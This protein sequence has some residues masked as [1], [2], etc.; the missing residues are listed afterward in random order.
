MIVYSLLDSVK[1]ANQWYVVLG[2]SLNIQSYEDSRDSAP[3]L[4]VSQAF[5]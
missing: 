2:L 5:I 3:H 1:L 4:F